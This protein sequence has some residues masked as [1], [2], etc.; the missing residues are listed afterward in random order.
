MSLL[1]IL[2]I[3]VAAGVALVAGVSRGAPEAALPKVIDFNRDIRPILS[4][5]CFA[6]HGPDEAKRK[7]KLRLDVREEALKPAKS[8][9]VAIVPGKAG[10]SELVKRITL[11]AD[12]DDVMPPAKSKKQLTARQVEL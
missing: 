11:A 12:H 6:C 7:S 1:K 9:A 4:E 3:A 8:G 10:A 5:N 2:S